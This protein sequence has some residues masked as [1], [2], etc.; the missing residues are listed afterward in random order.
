[1]SRLIYGKHPVLEILEAGMPKLQKIYLAKGLEKKDSDRISAMALEAKTPVE[2]VPRSWHDQQAKGGRHQGVAA[3]APDFVYAHL[4]ELLRKAPARA[5][6]VVLDQVE[7]PHNLGAILRS[8]EA[9]GALGAVIPKDH[10]AQ[11]TPLVEKAAAGAGAS[12]PVASVINLSQ[13]L[14]EI[15]QSGFWVY[16]LSGEAADLVDDEKFSEK[17]CLVLGREGKGLRP[18]VAKNCDKLLR[19]KMRGKISSY[20]V[21]VAAGISLYQV[22]RQVFGNGK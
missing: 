4:T 17:A 15:K 20:N 22:T 14:E 9:S 7:D 6:L 5:V 21:S 1:L 3:L 16:G 12:L 13:A 18:L 10:A 11:V 8:A 2:W 19:L